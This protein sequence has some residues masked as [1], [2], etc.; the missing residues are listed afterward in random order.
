[1]RIQKYFPFLLVFVFSSPLLCQW[2]EEIAI[3]ENDWTILKVK[4]SSSHFIFEHLANK[5]MAKVDHGASV[6]L[7]NH[8]SGIQY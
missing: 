1:M 5:N 7:L 2:N 6:A 3:K 8:I 4:T